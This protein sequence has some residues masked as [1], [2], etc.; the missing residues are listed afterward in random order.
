MRTLK[1]AQIK[2]KTVLLR[3]DFNVAVEGG[4]VVEDFRMRA[5]LPT[6]NHLINEGSKKMVIISHFGRP[7]GE[8]NSEYSLEPVARH[9]SELLGGEEVDFLNVLIGEEARN[10]VSSSPSR[11]VMLENLRFHKEEDSN[12]ED[13]SK[14]IASF[15]DFFVQDAFGVC[16]R[17]HA[18]I[19]GIPRF[20]DSYAGLLLEKEVTKL[21]SV[22]ENPKRPMAALIGGAKISTKIGVIKKFLE[23]ADNVCIGG[24][25][26][27]AA[28]QAR[29]MA[30][31]KS[32]VEEDIE[33]KIKNINFTDTHLHLPLDVK[34]AK[35]KDASSD[36]IIKA[37]GNVGDDEMILDI[38]PDTQELFSNVIHRS[39]TVIWNGPMGYIENEA[40]REGTLRIAQEIAKATDNGVF[41]VVGGGDTYPILAE[42]KIMD[43][44]SFVSTGG[45]AMLDFLAD[46]TLPGLEVL[47]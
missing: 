41:T 10:K 45:G 15:G 47:K 38:G 20:I 32:Y 3:V 1:E 7:K 36:I 24:A 31:G 35:D 19:V 13:F 22:V 17:Q 43:N 18:S 34:L 42:L 39:K 27:N 21:S 46:G 29:G 44:I 25:L 23:I 6:I 8:R 33:D 9:L 28:L 2:D 4:K 11:I 30:V 26:A 5:T 16:H 40:F 37:A 14:E 12:D